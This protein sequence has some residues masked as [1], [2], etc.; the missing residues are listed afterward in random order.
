MIN[1]SL[2]DF[3]LTGSAFT[4][5]AGIRDFDACFSQD[6]KHGFVFRNEEFAARLGKFHMKGFRVQDRF[7]VEAF[8][9]DAGFRISDRQGCINKLA[10]EGFGSAKIHVSA[11][12]KIEKPFRGQ[13][14]VVF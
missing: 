11:N 5:P 12:R 10:D 14:I 13:S 9:M 2:Q 8:V 4:N 3:E 1:I 7:G 6:L